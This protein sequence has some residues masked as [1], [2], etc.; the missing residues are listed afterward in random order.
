[1][2]FIAGAVGAIT[3]STAVFAC[4]VAAAD[5]YAGKTYGD[6]AGEL[7]GYGMTAVVAGRVGSALS[8]DNCIVTRSQKAPWLKGDNFQPVNNTMLLFLNCNDP[9]ASAGRSG[10][11]AA[12]PEGQQ[13]I[14]EQQAYV[15][16]STTE[17]GAQWCAESMKAHPDWNASAWDGCPGT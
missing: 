12:S 5:S 17:D 11:S 2:K 14:K 9:V 15:W 1:M 6:A 10:N 8:T 7:S 3:L 13:A 4:P 16:K